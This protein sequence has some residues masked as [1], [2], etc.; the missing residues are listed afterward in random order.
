MPVKRDRYFRARGGTAAIL[1]IR[2]SNCQNRV[3][4]YQKDGKG[5]LIRCYLN[6][7]VTPPEL[8]GLQHDPNVSE[9]GDMPNLTCPQCNLLIGTPM[10][11]IDGRL[12]FRLRRGAFAKNQI[13]S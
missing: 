4:T 12:A 11:H 9:A 7:I 3:L 10:R 8:E 6:R 1:E 13:R 5:A 2:C